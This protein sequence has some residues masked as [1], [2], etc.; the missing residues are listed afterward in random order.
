[1][2]DH[3]TEV[4]CAAPTEHASQKR[5]LAGCHVSGSFGQLIPNP[6]PN[7]NR[8]I[9]QQLFGNVVSAVGPGKY[10]D[11]FDNNETMECPS[12]RLRVESGTSAIPPDV[13]P[14]QVLQRPAG[15]PPQAIAAAEREMHELI[16]A[17]EVSHEDDEHLPPAQDEDEDEEGDGNFGDDMQEVQ[18]MGGAEPQQVH[19]SDG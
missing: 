11:V 19:D 18:P 7:K 15:A 17:I 3:F 4:M 14:I 6:D 13:P 5:L 10:L 12:N 2:T 16:Q 8:C 1:L 9:R